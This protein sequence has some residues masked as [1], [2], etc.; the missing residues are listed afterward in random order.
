MSDAI[1]VRG[2][3]LADGSLRLDGPLPLPPGEVEVMIRPAVKEPLGVVMERI[4]TRQQARGYVPRSAEEI[5]EQL[6][7]SA[8]EWD[9][10]DREIE[11][12]HDLRKPHRTPT[13]EAPG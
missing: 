7:Q 8:E 9:E 11:A 13:E 4:R 3:V 10:H 1:T 12:I 2:V 5:Q 6:R